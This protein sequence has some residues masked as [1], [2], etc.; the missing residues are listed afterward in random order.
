MGTLKTTREQYTEFLR[1]VQTRKKNGMTNG[2]KC[3]REVRKRKSRTFAWI[4]WQQVIQNMN[5]SSF[6][7]V[8]R[9]MGRLEGTVKS[10]RRCPLSFFR[11]TFLS[12]FDMKDRIES[13]RLSLRVF[14]PRVFFPS[15]GQTR[16]T[17]EEARTNPVRREV[18]GIQDGFGRRQ[19][20][21]WDSVHG[22][23]KT[24]SSKCQQISSKKWT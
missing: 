21:M 17:W 11:T 7:A 10:V 2:V 22:I 13:G 20:R 16:A 8:L 4:S 3:C 24:W 14:G 18:G 5:E 6:R 23:S 19:G 9:A 1:Y 15:K 12:T